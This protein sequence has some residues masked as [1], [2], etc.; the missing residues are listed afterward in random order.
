ME[1]KVKFVSTKK[2]IVKELEKTNNT[3]KQLIE[4]L[5]KENNAR[6]FELTKKLNEIYS[7]LFYFHQELNNL[8]NHYLIISPWIAHFNKTLDS[9]NFEQ[10][11]RSLIKD[12]D[13]K[14][15]LTVTK[16][17]ARVLYL[18]DKT[19]K[20]VGDFFSINEK[21]L[22]N[23]NRNELYNNIISFG[24]ECYAFNG[25]FMP[26]NNFEESTF[27]ENYGLDFIS[28][29]KLKNKDVI[30]A[31]AYVGDSS[32]VFERNLKA[33]NKIYAFE[34]VHFKNLLKTI[35]M[36]ESKKIIPINLAL[37]DKKSRVELK[38]E[39]M[40]ASISYSEDTIGLNEIA[41]CD[42][43]SLDEYVEKNNL[44]IGLIK[45][46]LEGYEMTFLKGALET[47]KQQRPTMIISIYHSAQDFFGIKAFIENLHL[48]YKFKIFKAN[49]GLVLAGT[50]LICEQN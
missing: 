4:T 9:I 17:I 18:K 7:N 13:D 25:Y 1:S 37:S 23:D 40:G 27:I 16:I 28:K 34:P 46:D 32:I 24:P 11:Y 20:D 49:D 22:I 12:L 50:L 26:I 48:G 41:H 35:K 19:I 3:F 39:G 44:H 6:I 2:A 36:N 5:N 31:G 8:T 45:T 14:S 43:I 10:A 33:I 38:G 30:D 15:I 47:I 21:K 42:S 29:E